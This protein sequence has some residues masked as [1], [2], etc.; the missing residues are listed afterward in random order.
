[1]AI[2]NVKSEVYLDLDTEKRHSADVTCQPETDSTDVY[3]LM[4]ADGNPAI[5]QTA[6]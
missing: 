2:A 1:M 3:G 6:M 5:L 4:T